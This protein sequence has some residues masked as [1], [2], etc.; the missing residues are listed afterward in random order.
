MDN[1]TYSLR[2]NRLKESYFTKNKLALFKLTSLLWSVL[3]GML[4]LTEDT[5][6]AENVHKSHGIS[7]FDHLKYPPDFKHFDY[8]N[9]DAPKGGSI[10]LFAQG[11]FDSMNPYG[12]SGV[13]P[14][15]SPTFN[16]MKYGFTEFNEPLMVG[17]GNY[18][19]S[20]DEISAAYGLIAQSAEY[21]D[22]NQWVIFNLRPEARFHDHHP[23]T[24]DDVVFSFNELRKKGHP[25]YKMQLEPIAAVEKL[26]SHRIKF[27]FKEPGHRGQLL[28]AAELPVLPQHYWQN[29]AIEK[30]TF[31][32]PLNSGPYQVTDVKQGQSITFTRVKDYWGK[33]LAVNKGRYNFDQVTIYFY[34]DLHAAFEAFKAGGHDIHLEIIAKNWATAYD[35]SAIKSGH[36]KKKE[37][38]H[39]MAYGSSFFFFNTRRALFK[40]ELVRRALSLMMDFQWTNHVIFHNSYNRSSSYFPN[41]IMAAQ[42]LPDLSELK[43]LSPWRN[44]LPVAL[45]T[46]P[47]T[48]SETDGSG[49]VRAQ[50]QQAISL[51]NKA[52]WQHRNKRLIHIE[53]NTPFSFEFLEK[54]HAVHR[55][56]LPWKKNLELIGIEMN[57]RRID[58][59]QYIQRVRNHDFDVIEYILP[60]TLAPDQEVYRY[61]H[62]SQ[63]SIP[64]SQNLAGINHPAIDSIVEAIPKAKTLKELQ[65][66]VHSLDRILLWK[67]YG[68]PKWYTKTI[69]VAYKNI[70]G[71]PEKTPQFATPFSTWWQK[72]LPVTSP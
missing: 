7:R 12:I 23:I 43:V 42:D 29:K 41:S 52:G 13:T 24:A 70:F 47:F 19:P 62:S 71:W 22:N 37:I 38:P 46:T 32:P 55:Y 69:R 33:D 16:F 10:R 60:Q 53:S 58:I 54:N 2:L 30:T 35:F 36:I 72:K 1:S 64:G 59:S 17:S 20:G 18:S 66:L 40:D 45:F 11:T 3:A 28:R 51:L 49:S 15:Q 39:Q 57:L 63:A 68:V 4:I 26:N 21:P 48:V 25:R 31:T 65:A 34:R 8:V 61:F 67:H 9:P 5:Y 44:K 14:A 56:V 27:T 6:G 50:M